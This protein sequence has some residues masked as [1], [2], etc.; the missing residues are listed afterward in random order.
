VSLIL[1]LVSFIPKFSHFLDHVA[2]IL[3]FDS[4]GDDIFFF[5]ATG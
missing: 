5:D 3:R 2:M 1:V 4:E